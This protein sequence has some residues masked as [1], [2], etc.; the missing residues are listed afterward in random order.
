[1]GAMMGT[2]EWRWARVVRWYGVGY[3]KIEVW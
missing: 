3:V 2:G 1:M